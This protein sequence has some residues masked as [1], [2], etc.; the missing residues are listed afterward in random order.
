M[1]SGQART[2]APTVAVLHLGALV[3][4]DPEADLAANADLE[5]VSYSDLVLD[6]LDL[7]GARLD[8]VHLAQVSA[9]EVDLKGARFTEVDLDQVSFTV[10]LASRT[11]WRDVQVAGR[12][13]SVEAYESQWRSVHFVNCKLSYANLRGAELIDVLF[14]DCIIGELDLVGAVATRVSLVD[15]RVAN[16]DVQGARLR[17]FDLRRASFEAV[18]GLAGLRGATLSPAQLTLLAPRFADELGLRIED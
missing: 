4:G 7:A 6:R 8:G 14:T 3:D 5:S 15:T 16:L 10:V 11:Q 18:D 2:K 9:D 1:S 12:L 17:D 13:G